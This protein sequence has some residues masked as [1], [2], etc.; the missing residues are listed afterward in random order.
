VNVQEAPAAIEPLAA[1]QDSVPVLLIE[2][3]LGFPSVFVGLMPVAVV[4]ELFVKVNVIGELDEPTLIEPKF[5]GEGES[6][7]AP[8]S[9]VSGCG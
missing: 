2:K 4:L 7:T 5:S 1:S 9:E 3:S 6:A 8:P